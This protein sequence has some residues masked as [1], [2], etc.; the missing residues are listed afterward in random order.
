MLVGDSS[1]GN[2][3]MVENT[4][5]TNEQSYTKLIDAK[6]IIASHC[7]AL[8]SKQVMHHRIYTAGLLLSASTTE[9]EKIIINCNFKASEYS[10]ECPCPLVM[11]T[12][13]MNETHI[14]VR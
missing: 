3:T 8:N 13:R 12:P 6:Q 2:I 1:I 14:N 10:N 4:T 9:N 11:H 7:I 5:I